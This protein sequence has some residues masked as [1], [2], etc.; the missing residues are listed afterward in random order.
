MTAGKPVVA[1]DGGGVR[2]WLDHERTGFIVPHGDIAGFAKRVDQLMGDELLRG[3]M[4]ATARATAK[5][6]FSPDAHIRSLLG[7]YTEVL[8][9]SSADRSRGRTEICDAQRGIGV[10]V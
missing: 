1:F 6:R 2:Q 4:G 10:S 8:N 9:E 3:L 5:A 7:I